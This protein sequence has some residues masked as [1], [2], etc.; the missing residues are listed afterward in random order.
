[1][2]TE[3][4]VLYAPTLSIAGE[5]SQ[6]PVHPNDHWGRIVMRRILCI[7]DSAL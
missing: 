5:R 4:F 7:T 6:M 2:D 3:G 1:M